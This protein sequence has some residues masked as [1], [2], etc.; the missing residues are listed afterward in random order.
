MSQHPSFVLGTGHDVSGDPDNYSSFINDYIVFRITVHGQ[1]NA[2]GHADKHMILNGILIASQENNDKDGYDADWMTTASLRVEAGG[3]GTPTDP[4]AG[5]TR[6][7]WDA[8]NRQAALQ[9][10]GGTKFLVDTAEVNKVLTIATSDVNTSTEVI[11]ENNH[12]LETGVPIVYS[13][14]GGTT[15]AGLTHDT[16]YYAIRVDDNDFKVAT[17]EANATAGTAINL[18]GTGNNSQTFTRS[19]SG[20]SE[21]D[22]GFTTG[23]PFVYNNGGGT[24]IPGLAND[25]KYY[26][27]KV[28]DNDFQLAT[29][30]AN[31]NAGT[32]YT[33][34]GTGNNSQY[35]HRCGGG[36]GLVYLTWGT[37]EAIAHQYIEIEYVTRDNTN[38]S[39]SN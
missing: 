10:D 29:S 3:S 33:L 6:H 35:F 27:I 2:S 21:L 24:T 1:R 20:I 34:T 17:S 15:L 28:S 16:T 22:H 39:N 8:T 30:L 11:T 7:E 26:A 32:A 4:T 25:K 18:T 13:N 31:A 37:T 38:W 14:G 12:L 9:A 19:K 36:A 23:T 5:I